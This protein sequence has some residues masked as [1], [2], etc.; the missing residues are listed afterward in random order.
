[1]ERVWEVVQDIRT[2]YL[3]YSGKGSGQSDPGL[4]LEGCQ[5]RGGEVF[6]CNTPSGGLATFATL[7]GV[8]Y[9]VASNSGKL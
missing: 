7:E 5:A 4:T 2:S 8:E 1:M 9:Y 6:S 3:K